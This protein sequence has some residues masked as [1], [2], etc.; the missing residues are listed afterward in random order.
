MIIQYVTNRNFSIILNF[1]VFTGNFY[2]TVKSMNTEEENS[3][4][5]KMT[6]PTPEVELVV[7]LNSVVFKTLHSIQVELKSFIEDS[8]NERKEQ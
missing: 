4:Q 3:R 5:G 8:L 2:S 7:E 6:M 1:F